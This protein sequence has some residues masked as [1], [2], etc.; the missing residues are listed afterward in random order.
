MIDQDGK[1]PGDPLRGARAVIAA[2][3]EEPPPHR[4]VLGSG[5]YDA[6]TSTLREAMTDIIRS[7]AASRAADFPP[8]T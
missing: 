6:V 1:Q 5:A 8:G 2:M 4:L 7:E 3:A